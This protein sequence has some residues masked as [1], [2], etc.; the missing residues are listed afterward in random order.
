MTDTPQGE[1][2]LLE[3]ASA[4]VAAQM[5][6]GMFLE[7]GTPPTRVVVESIGDGVIAARIFGGVR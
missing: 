4:A 5:V 6:V 1:L 3:V 7:W 2:M